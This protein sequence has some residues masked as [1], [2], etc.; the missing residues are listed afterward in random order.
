MSTTNAAVGCLH[1]LACFQQQQQ[2]QQYEAAGYF[3]STT[4]GTSSVASWLLHDIPNNELVEPLQVVFVVN[5]V[6]E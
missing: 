2:Q 4:T 1:I 6:V 5:I 3:C